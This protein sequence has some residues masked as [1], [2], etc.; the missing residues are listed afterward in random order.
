MLAPEL[1]TPRSRVRR[2]ARLVT[3]VLGAAALAACAPVTRAGETPRPAAGAVVVRNYKADYVTI[4]IARRGGMTWR[5]GEL[6]GFGDRMFS[7]PASALADVDE[8][9]LV[10]RPLAGQ[11]FRSESFVIPSGA[12]AVW[13]I[14]GQTSLSHVAVRG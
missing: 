8:V 7:L 10:A 5:L 14:E 12:T 6:S 13:T 3:G 11:P 4:Y 1:F 2:S 9:Y